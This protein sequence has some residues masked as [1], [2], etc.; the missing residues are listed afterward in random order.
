MESLDLAGY[1][2]TSSGPDFTGSQDPGTVSPCQRGSLCGDADSGHRVG[3]SRAHSKWQCCRLKRLR[4]EK[5][6]V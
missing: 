2:G 3:Q 4:N 6:V 1:F 5:N